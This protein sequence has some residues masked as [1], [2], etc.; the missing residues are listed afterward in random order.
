MRFLPLATFGLVCFLSSANAAQ[1]QA[2]PPIAAEVIVAV[3]D[4]DDAFDELDRV[5]EVV[6]DI[7]EK[8][9]PS[10]TDNRWTD[11][12]ANNE[13][14]ALEIAAAPVPSDYTASQYTVSLAA[15]QDCSQRSDTVARLKGFLG[16]LSGIR[17]AIAASQSRIN[18]HLQRVGTAKG[19]LTYLI[20]VHSKL[21]TD[22]YPLYGSMF[23]WD[24]FELDTSV[25][26]SLGLVDSALNRQKQHTDATLATID[27]R[28]A[29][30]QGNIQ[31]VANMSCPP[32]GQW[33]GSVTRTKPGFRSI[34]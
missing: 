24:W 21:A 28:F 15:L 20:D 10:V 13:K 3:K 16:E 7:E 25:R 5:R 9:T 12:A 17:N 11:L 31:T 32:V 22:A 8:R 33:S 26:K 18:E 1:A 4:M 2:L 23:L 14:A 6:K 30:L 27:A 29:N 34:S 19:V